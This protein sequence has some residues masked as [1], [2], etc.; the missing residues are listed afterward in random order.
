MRD[1]REHGGTTHPAPATGDPIHPSSL[2]PHPW[3]VRWRTARDAGTTRADMISLGIDI[4]GTSV[5]AA[6][7]RDGALVWTGKSG[8]FGRPG[9]EQ[10][11]EAIPAD[12]LSTS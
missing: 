9:T 1:E 12:A 10:I 5:K 11:I 2:N 8:T 7:L 3:I 6:A 4:G